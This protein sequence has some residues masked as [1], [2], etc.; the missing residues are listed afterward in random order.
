MLLFLDNAE[1][2]LDP[3]GP[4]GE[5]IYG[6]VEELGQF[7]NICLAIT[8]RITTV[9]PDCKCLDIPTL[10]ME[11]ARRTFYRIYD[12]NEQPDLVDKILEQLDFHPLSVT[13]LA[14][15]A[16]QNKWENDRLVREWEKHRTGVLQPRHNKS[17]ADTI[18]LSLAS[19]MFRQL[20]PDARDLLGV[21][22]FFPQGINES[23][24][25]WLFPT[26]PDRATV[27]DT[28]C[29]L[30]LAHRHNGF[31]TMLIP[32]RDYLCPRD[33]LPSPL[34][35]RVKESYFARLPAGI[36]PDTPGFKEARWITSEDANVEHFLN[37]LT[38]IDTNSDRVWNACASF[39][40]HLLW[41]KP[42]RTV[43]GPKVEA[44]PDDHPSKPRCLLQ[45]AR[46]IGYAGNFAEEKRLLDHALRLERERGVDDRVAL[47]LCNLSD[48]NRMVHL[49]GEGIRQAKEALEIYERIGDI[50]NQGDSLVKLALLLY[51]DHQLGAA[52]EAA[53]RVVE[54]LPEKGEEFRVC[55][56]HHVL[57]S[58]CHS[59]GRREEAVHHFKTALAIATPFNWNDQLFWIHYSLTELFLDDDDFDNA[60]AHIGQAK[61]YAIDSAYLLGRVARLQAD[62]LYDQDRLEDARSEALRAL[63]IFGKIGATEDLGECEHLLRD[64]EEGRNTSGESNSSCGLLEIILT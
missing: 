27:F 63:E 35:C 5:E 32:L 10:S 51:D 39:L 33:P 55:R 9:P 48:A 47:V 45:L 23:N 11:A 58:I 2:I 49:Y 29:A 4:D 56:S 57:G 34:F 31:V 17:L 30:S 52:E 53:L 19:P 21:I 54:L 42:R 41:H 13:L 50:G 15:V 20:G 28:F 12:N 18:E 59:K 8:S 24:L 37:V 40:E 14:T 36:N 6:I 1:S 26:I 64:I 25:D 62:A 3:Q 46:S 44:L 43:L 38:S 22:A 7:G 16:L 60:Y 61:S